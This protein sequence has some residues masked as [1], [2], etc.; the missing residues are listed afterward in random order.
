MLHVTIDVSL[1]TLINTNAGNA[2]VKDIMKECLGMGIRF[3]EDVDLEV[4]EE[5][6]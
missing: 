3:P 1:E 5:T 2:I 4:I 6:K